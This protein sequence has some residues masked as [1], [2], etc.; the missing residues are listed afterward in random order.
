AAASARPRGP[1]VTATPR[2]RSGPRKGVSLSSTP[3]MSCPI[4][5]STVAIALMPAP[6]TFT[7]WMRRGTPRSM[8]CRG[9]SAGTGVLLDQCGDAIGGIGGGQGR[10]PLGHG[11][12]PIGVGEQRVD[13]GDQ[14]LAVELVVAHHHRPTG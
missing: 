1:T 5:A 6:P 8:D 9:R 12:E 2:S 4:W 7:T 3:E 10:H 13:L 14:A 11:A